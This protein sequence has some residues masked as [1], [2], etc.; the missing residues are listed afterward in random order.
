[1]YKS[2]IIPVD[3]SHSERIQPMV[4]AARVLAAEDAEIL[5]LNVIEDI[6]AYVRSQVPQSIRDERDDEVRNQ[7]KKIARDNGLSENIM[8]RTGH[9]PSEILAAAKQK[10]SDLIVI[11]SHKPGF[12]DFLLGS[13]AA[14]VVRH[15]A[16]TV[17]VVRETG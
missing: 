1:M 4:A 5:L 3:L 10:K 8:V 11:A 2:V 14:R 16:C 15:S 9:A 13:T 7:L 6:P 17:H 12:G